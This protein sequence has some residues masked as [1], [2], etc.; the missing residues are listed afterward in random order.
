MSASMK[1]SV[2]MQ[3]IGAALSELLDDIAGE[4]IPFVLILQA[5]NISQYL[6]NCDRKDGRQLLEDLLERW[7][8][9]RAD[10]PAHYNPD[11][12]KQ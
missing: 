4:P 1:L 9:G 12:P 3:A 10:I 7:K 5:D 6:S 8:A 2:D 11:L